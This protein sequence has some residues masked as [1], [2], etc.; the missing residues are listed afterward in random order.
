MTAWA[1][2]LRRA[3]ITG[4]VASATSTVALAL[5]A[6]SEGKGALQPVNATSHWLNGE[7]SAGVQ[8]F[9]TVHTAVGYAT[10]HAATLFWA[11]IFETWIGARPPRTASH[12][13]ADAVT[14]SAIA[15]AVDYG[16]TPK[17][18]TPGWEFVLSKRSMAA[19]YAAMAFGLAA[20]ALM[21]DE[22]RTHQR[23]RSGL[24]RRGTPTAGNLP[25]ARRNRHGTRC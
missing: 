10:H 25:V 14:M 21:T 19:A 9:D 4:T 20:G 16:P 6:L 8:G 11:A 15:A 17:R 18:F 3:L 5:L 22:R 1:T 23:S 13:V 12:L 2:I 7:Q 24:D